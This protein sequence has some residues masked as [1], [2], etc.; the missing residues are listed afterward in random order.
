MQAQT[1]RGAESGGEGRGRLR[2]TE[3]RIVASSTPIWRASGRGLL[4][5]ELSVA[6]VLSDRH[7]YYVTRSVDGQIK[8]GPLGSAIAR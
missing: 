2:A 4:F 6:A 1:A 7:V 3:A 8:S 5:D